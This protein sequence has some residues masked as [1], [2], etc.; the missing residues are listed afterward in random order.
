MPDV[1]SSIPIRVNDLKEFGHW[2]SKY[3]KRNK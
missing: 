3:D 1:T 2:L